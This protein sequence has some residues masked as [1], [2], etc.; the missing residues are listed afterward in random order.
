VL[1][2][3]GL[4]WPQ[5][6]DSNSWCQSPPPTSPD[7]GLVLGGLR[8]RRR[9]VPRFEHEPVLGQKGG[10]EA[11]RANEV[12]GVPGYRNRRITRE[13]GPTVLR[14]TTHGIDALPRSV[15]SMR[16]DSLC[17]PSLV[18]AICARAASW[19]RYPTPFGAAPGGAWSVSR[20]TLGCRRPRPFDRG[21]WRVTTSEAHPTEASSDGS[22]SSGENSDDGISGAEFQKR[23]GF[24]PLM[25]ALKPRPPFQVLVMSEESRLGRDHASRRECGRCA[26]SSSR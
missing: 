18:C 5:S 12:G 16:K 17:H 11:A 22:N 15:L 9:A 3:V 4:E 1:V 20:W 24:L 19:A 23:P 21:R 26:R 25:N 7:T 8:G 13:G 2:R 10:A 14:F 6:H